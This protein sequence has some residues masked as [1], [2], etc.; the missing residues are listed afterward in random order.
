MLP[1][2]VGCRIATKLRSRA[3]NPEWPGVHDLCP[4]RHGGAGAGT[5]PARSRYRRVWSRCPEGES[6]M[7]LLNDFNPADPISQLLR[8]IRIRSTV[9]CRSLLSAPWGFGVQAHCN[10]AFHVVTSGG[11]WL[12]VDG[13]TAQLALGAGDLVV[14][15]AGPAH[16]TRDD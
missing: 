10:P 8:V 2:A 11:C 15:P 4:N 13:E 5:A 12:Q 16:E 7:D 1:P 6:P 9:Y 14:L 3:R